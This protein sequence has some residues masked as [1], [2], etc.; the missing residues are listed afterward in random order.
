MFQKA[1]QII[2]FLFG[3]A[4][5]NSL[6][7]RVFNT[8]S[9]L[10]GIANLG[11]SLN[12][13]D[14]AQYP[15]FLF[16][17][18]LVSGALFLVFYYL[19]RFLNIYRVLYWPFLLLISGFLT[20]SILRDAGSQGGSHYYMIMA[21]LVGTILARRIGQVLL[22]FVMFTLLTAGLFYIE[23][24][25]PEMIVPYPGTNEERLMELASQFIFMMIFTAVIVEI[26]VRNLNQERGKSDALLL[27]ILPESI[28]EELKRNDRV[29]PLHYDGATV[30]FTD[31]VGFTRIAE[32]L[33]PQELIEELDNC[34]RLFDQIMRK[35]NLEKIKTIGDAYMAVAGI[36]EANP[37]HAVDAVLA[38]L[39]IQRC[40]EQLKNEKLAQGR[41]FWELR[42]GIHSGPLVA[43]VIGEKKFAYDV[44]G[45]TVNTASR[46]ESS[47]EKARV[48]ISG[49]TYH[50]VQEFFQCEFR[51][52][53]HAKN[54]GDIEMYFVTGIL[55]HLA[56]ADGVTPNERFQ[57]RYWAL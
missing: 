45:D 19:S 18:H 48:N 13:I 8:I 32:Q 5:R 38:A 52:N 47:G 31:F 53:V 11:G 22:A 24:Y 49:V 37:T 17:A 34:F 14:F 10:F 56:E 25:D 6:E 3:D 12:F 15:V 40:M 23:I 35:H 21:V 43:G 51:G 26:L 55:P 1:G 54:K 27:N 33:S 50:K 29:A 20:I 30:L 9:L 28:A 4:R 2:A 36:P 39:Q 42:L 57:S 16:L 7:H 41:D 44:W 46:L